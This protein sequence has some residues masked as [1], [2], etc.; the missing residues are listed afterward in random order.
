M[1][2]VATPD[3]DSWMRRTLGRRTVSFKIPEHVA[4]YTRET[5]ARAVKDHFEVVH[6]EPVGQYCTTDF[7]ERRLATVSPVL[8]HLF[9][10]AIATAGAKDWQPYVSSGSLLAVLARH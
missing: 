5:L 9:R 6:A 3:Y 4:Y 2:I 8:G 1:A 7:V 10:M